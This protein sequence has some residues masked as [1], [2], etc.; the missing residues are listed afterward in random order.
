MSQTTAKANV[1]HCFALCFSLPVSRSG[2]N[3][4][5][6]DLTSGRRNFANDLPPP[7]PSPTLLSLGCALNT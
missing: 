7:V 1:D 6:T 2:L 3:D 5:M 4:L